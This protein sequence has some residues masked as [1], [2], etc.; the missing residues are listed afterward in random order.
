MLVLVT[1][2]ALGALVE[3]PASS[4]TDRSRI[5]DLGVSIEAVRSDR[6]W[7][8]A[9]PSV[10]ARLKA[11]G[12]P[13]HSEHADDLAIFDFP[14]A[15]SR[16]H[17]YSE[18]IA[19]LKSLTQKHADICRLQSIGKSIENREIL[20]I[21]IN[22]EPEAL[23]EGR[24]NKPGALFL[25]NH[26]AR[27]HLS[28]EVPL[29][30]AQYLLEH[31]QDAQIQRLLETRDIWI[32]P[33][34]NPD[35]L[36]FDIATGSYKWWR[37][38]RRANHDGSSGVDLNR[39]YSFKWGTGGSSNDPT[40]DVYMGPEPFSEP[41]TKSVREFIDAHANLKV[42]LSF[43]TFSELILYP[44][45]HTYDS[46]GNNRDRLVFEK[47]AKTMATWNR[48]KPQQ[49]SDLYIASGDTT[50]W[51]YGT[52]GIFAFTFEL[53]PSSSMDGG[54]YPGARVIDKVFQDNLKPCLYLLDLADD[55]YRAVERQPGRWLRNYVE[56]SI[57]AELFWETH[58]L[59]HPSSLR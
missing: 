36:E 4:R 16:F 34:V 48:Y 33:T 56:P 53:S 39:N 5:A 24:S 32:V 44:W 20:A 51:A 3:L 45:G 58:P 21:H 25:G 47:M 1:N 50:D 27:E 52:H 23:L 57:P 10:I 26:H 11:A 6:V 28:L 43:H 31:R 49:A 59:A 9:S 7:G 14:P 42:L 54:F 29:M 37:K 12:I 13:V 55:P 46:I 41:E 8:F 40:S 19:A 30:F 2:G 38:N 18:T 15:D 35:G 17:N 22:T